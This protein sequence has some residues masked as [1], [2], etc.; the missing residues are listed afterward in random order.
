MQFAAAGCFDDPEEDVTRGLGGPEIE[1]PRSDVTQWCV[2]NTS[3]TLRLSVTLAEPRNPIV[4]PA[5]NEFGSTIIL[6]YTDIDGEPRTLNLGKGRTDDRFEYYAFETDGTAACTGDASFEDGQYVAVV[7]Q[8]CLSAPLSISGQLSMFYG[9]DADGTFENSPR[10]NAPDAGRVVIPR[11]EVTGAEDIPRLFGLERISTAIEVSRASFE[12]GVAGEVV[13][14]SSEAFPDALVA[15][16]LASA[17]DGPVLLTPNAELPPMV[18]DEIVRAGGAAAPVR[19]M[20]GTLAVSQ[21][22]ENTLLEAGHPVTRVAGDNRFATSVAAA[23]SANSNPTNILLAFGGEFGGAL[24]S[25]AAST[26][27]DAT[28]VLID[29][30]G[31]PDVVQAYLERHPEAMKFPVG[32]VAITAAPE[33]D[34]S[35]PGDSAAA[36]SVQMAQIFEVGQEVDEVV[37]ASAEAFPDGLTGG[38]YAAARQVPLLLTPRDG[39]DEGVLLYLQQTGPLDTIT[40]FGGDAALSDTVAAQAAANLAPEE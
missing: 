27:L 18:L 5:W 21:D 16:P 3:R 8:S 10:D 38:A 15:A 2:D 31:V 17:V 30:D 4:D 20:G 23:E 37:I 9:R 14:A 11:G 34:G 35:V 40:F 19:I 7:P 24:V 12:D 28:V 26:F 36:V 6:F 1:V 29:R 13:L 39:M 22:V 33:F 25:G 32:R